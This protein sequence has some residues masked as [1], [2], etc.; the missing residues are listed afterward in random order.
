MSPTIALGASTLAPPLSDRG[1]RPG[2]FFAALVLA[3]G[4]AL[5][6]AGLAAIAATLVSLAGSGAF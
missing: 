6:C 4:V 1:P 2:V 3:P 5:A